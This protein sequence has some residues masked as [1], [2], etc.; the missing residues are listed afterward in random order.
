MPLKI[1]ATENMGARREL[2]Q[3]NPRASAARTKRSAESSKATRRVTPEQSPPATAK[4]Q[5]GE[6]TGW[7]SWLEPT[8]SRCCTELH[9]D[10]SLSDRSN[11]TRF[12]WRKAGCSRSS[13]NPDKSPTTDYHNTS[14]PVR[15]RPTTSRSVRRASHGTSAPRGHCQSRCASPR[16]CRETRR[17]EIHRREPPTP[18]P[19]TPSAAMESAAAAMRC[20]GEIWLAENSRAQQ[21]SCNAHHTPPFPG[22]GSA[23]A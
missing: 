13:H 19:E 23:I 21:R 9:T 3:Q 16:S 6:F 2:L 17:R 15:D 14:T 1:W 10:N 11:S 18:D 20:V 12:G 22:L 5:P 4:S 7:V 8:A